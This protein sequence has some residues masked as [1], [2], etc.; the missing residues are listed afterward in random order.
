M[1]SG[2]VLVSFAAVRNNPRVSVAGSNKTFTYI[3][4]QGLLFGFRGA[5][6]QFSFSDGV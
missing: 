1:P 5:D 3:T 6:P 4:H 2:G